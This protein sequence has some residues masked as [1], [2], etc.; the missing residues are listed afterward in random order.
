MVSEVVLLYRSMTGFTLCA[1]ALFDLHSDVSYSSDAGEPAE[2]LNS[3]S[4]TG[5]DPGFEMGGGGKCMRVSVYIFIVT[6]TCTHF[7]FKSTTRFGHLGHTNY[8]HYHHN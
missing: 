6:C 7:N 2:R 1:H 8:T 3:W 5:V 4:V